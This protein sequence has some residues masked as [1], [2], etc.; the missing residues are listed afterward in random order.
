MVEGLLNPMMPLF[1]QDALLLFALLS[2]LPPFCSFAL[3][4]GFL[5]SCPKLSSFLSITSVAISLICAVLLLLGFRHPVQ[6][7]AT[8]MVTGDWSLP[9]GFL[10]DP[11]SLLMLVLVAGISFLVQVYSVGYMAADP[12]YSRYFAFQSLFAWAMMSLVLSS[13]LLQLYV[14]WELVGL[15]SYLLIGFWYEKFS[16]SQAGKKAFVMT[17]VGDVAL[18]VG[19][20]LILIHT[21]GVSI[22]G[23]NSSDIPS[24]MSHELL[25]LSALLIFMGIIGKSAQFPL[26]TW[27][28]D[29][30]EGP[31][32]VSAL[33][34]SATMV[35][36][37]VYLMARLL[38]FLSYAEAAMTVFLV[39]GTITMLLGSTMAMVERDLKR[40]WAYSTVSQ[41]GFMIMGLAAGGFFEGTFHLTTHAVFKALL[42]LCSGVWIHLYGTNDIFAIGRHGARRMK[43]PMICI[44]LAAASLSGIPPLSGFFSKEAVM[45]TLAGLGSPVWIIAG[46]VGIFLTAYYAFRPLFVILLPREESKAGFEEKAAKSPDDLGKRH[47]AALYRAML[48][49]LVLLAFLTVLLGLIEPV[50]RSFLLG[51]GSAGSDSHP[52]TVWTSSGMALWGVV[53]AWLEFGRKGSQRV[54]FAERVAPIRELFAKRWYLD[55]AYELVLEYGVYRTFAALCS[56]NDRQVID[57]GVDGLAGFTVWGGRILSALQSGA[58]RYNMALPFVTVAL[59]VLC[60]FL[61]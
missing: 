22:Q 2:V 20:L 25:T 4:M 23:L 1:G 47:H 58:L 61:D 55:H 8:W 45:G 46:F 16:A 35:A 36:A 13:S 40:I 21:G 17:R 29:A 10:L 30:M 3:I 43:A 19:I 53:L 39:I 49:P 14:F 42:F 51:D 60:L 9:F 54:G 52:W 26:L 41:L 5:R 57:G 24:R 11:T 38:P 28:P 50:L 6:Y 56:R 37:G 27:L 15:S 44:F 31:T 32:P 12:G 7:S 34:H 33:L 59:V 18:F 48:W